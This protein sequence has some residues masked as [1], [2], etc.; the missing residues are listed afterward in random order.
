MYLTK[1]I[2]EPGRFKNYLGTN[3]LLGI[4][5]SSFVGGRWTTPALIA[6]INVDGYNTCHPA[7]SPDGKRMYFASDRPGGFGRMD[8]WYSDFVKGQWTEPKNMGPVINTSFNEVY[9]TCAP[10]G[11]L[12]FSSNRP[13]KTMG[14]LDIFYSELINGQWIEPRRIPEPFNSRYNDLCFVPEGNG[15]RGFFS[16]DRYDRTTSDVFYFYTTEP[17]FGSA[18]PLKVPRLCY[19]F[20]ENNGVVIDTAIAV[21]EWTFSDGSKQEV[22]KPTT[23]SLAPVNTP[24]N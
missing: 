15:D 2:V 11:R 24:L 5:E 18:E 10:D 14:K 12:Y 17:K 19:T 21:Y 9:P 3:N 16:S 23:A 7:L 4:F 1:N 13:D 22:W 20:F 8:L 6:A